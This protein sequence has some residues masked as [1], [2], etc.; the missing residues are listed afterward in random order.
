MLEN[1]VSKLPFGLQT[2][3]YQQAVK[4]L[5]LVAQVLPFP[6][7]SLFTGPGSS[8]KLC[9]AIAQTGTKKILIVTDEILVKIGLLKEIEKTLT[10]NG[11]NYVIYDGVLPDPTYDQVEKGL[12]LLKKNGCEAILAVGGGSSIDA[13]KAISARVT[14]DKP[15]KKLTGYFKVWK[16][17][18]PLF[19]IPTTAGTGSEVTVVSVV[20]DP[21]THQ[22]TPIIDPKMVPLLAALDGALMT[23]LPPMLTATTG[24]DALTH[25][26]EAYIS[27]GALPDTDL[28]AI[29]A[30]R[31]ISENLSKAVKDGKNVDVRQNM[32]QASFYAGMAF[33]KAGIGYVHAI[34]H[35]L[36]AFY[37]IPHGLA[38]A[39][40][41]PHILEYSKERA[42]E[43]LA[44]L[45]E[46][47]GLKKGKESHEQLA[48]KF[49]DYIRAMLA[50][51]NIPE[52]LDSIQA[53]DIPAIAKAA[54]KEAH[55]D[56][57][58]VPEYMDQATCESILRKLMV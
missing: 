13:A 31:L 10:E 15:L 18:M 48:Q 16:A 53:K 12:T 4:A 45:A 44:K 52:K 40:V 36:G 34:S 21:V 5:K 47:C 25:A 33:T 8:L 1:G 23:G 41:L 20:S 26:V 6:K 38:N 22:K 11:V 51:F 14:N 35:N 54:L 39:V 27:K 58:G 29:A 37:H 32:A 49:I 28:F 55:F 57:Y 3:G 24:M 46:I 50:E 7:P 43:R 42:S 56:I 30:T 17:C 9:E 19:V 2:Q